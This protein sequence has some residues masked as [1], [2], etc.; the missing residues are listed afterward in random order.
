[1]LAVGLKRLGQAAWGVKRDVHGVEQRQIAHLGT[2]VKVALR[3]DIFFLM[4][5]IF[6]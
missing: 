3:K 5:M 6:D 4:T 2:T 1:M